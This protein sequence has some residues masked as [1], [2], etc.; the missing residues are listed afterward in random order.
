MCSC[1]KLPCT[2]SKPK[3]RLLV[4]T[5]H[6]ILKAQLSGELLLQGPSGQLCGTAIYFAIVHCVCIHSI[7]FYRTPGKPTYLCSIMCCLV[8]NISVCLYT[9]LTKPPC[10]GEVQRTVVAMVTHSFHWCYSMIACVTSLF[11]SFHHAS[12]LLRPHTQTHART[13]TY[14]KL[15]IKLL[16]FLCM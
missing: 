4:A 1:V 6:K 11:D 16:Q 2:I 8:D 10:I 15:T 12:L 5:F 7:Q 3:L 13:Y 14:T 9:W